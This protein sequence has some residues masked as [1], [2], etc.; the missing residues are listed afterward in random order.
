MTEQQHTTP[1]PPADQ[2]L[3]WGGRQPR[4]PKQKW[5]GK[6]TAAAIAI[7][8][9]VA[10]AGGVAVYA[11]S[12]SAGAASPSMGGPGGMGGMGGPRGGMGGPGGG[13]MNAVHGEFTISDGNGG[14]KT[15]LMQTGQVTAISSTSVTA[16][17]ADGYTK[18]YTISSSTT[19]G[20]GSV[21]D[22]QNGDTVMITA[23]PSGEA[24]TADTLIERDQNAQGGPGG[25]MPP[26]NGQVPQGN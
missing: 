3:A 16:K 17:S 24:A 11:A 9:A 18:T 10:G 20:N 23:T 1:V 25:G 6:K 26:G 8:V 21:S 14:Y 4:R 2:E 13:L 12:G 22:I 5:S 19:F 15:E 7:A